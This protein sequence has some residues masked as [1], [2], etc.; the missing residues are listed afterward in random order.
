[1]ICINVRD[2]SGG[3]VDTGFGYEFGNVFLDNDCG[4]EFGNEFGII[5]GDD[6]CNNDYM[7]GDKVLSYFLCNDLGNIV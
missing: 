5:F 1:M 7:F 3:D 2:D 6:F 4:N